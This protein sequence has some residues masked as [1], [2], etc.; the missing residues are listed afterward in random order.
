MHSLPQPLLKSLQGVTGFD[1]ESFEEAHESQNQ[2][3]SIRI[4]PAKDG[5]DLSHLNIKEQVGWCEYG[6]Y[7][8]ER[9][10]FTLDPVFHGGAYYV[11]EASSMFLHYIVKQLYKDA[12][13]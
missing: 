1:A 3:T 6:Y 2:I 8:N 13:Q 9:P 7:L 4:N 10:S 5:F 12:E 11:Q